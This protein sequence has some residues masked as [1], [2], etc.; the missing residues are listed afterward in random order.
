MEILFYIFLGIAFD[1]AIFEVLY[2]IGKG[3]PKMSYNGYKRK[4]G[5][6]GPYS[7]SDL[8]KYM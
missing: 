6:I 3:R 8:H 7:S 2:M 4:Y 5:S 1:V